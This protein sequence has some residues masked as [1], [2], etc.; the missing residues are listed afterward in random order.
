MN[1]I[2]DYLV[3]KIL[4]EFILI[5]M[6]IIRLALWRVRHDI[7]SVVKNHYGDKRLNVET[8][9]SDSHKDDMGLFRD[10]RGYTPTPYDRLKR[11]IDYLKLDHDDVFIDF[12]CGKGRV[13]FMVAE[14]KLKK[15]IGVELDKKLADIAHD[16][17]RNLRLQNTPI[18][19]INADAA[20]FAVEEGTVFFL[21]DPFGY[22]TCEKVVENI[23][24]SLINRPRKIRILYWGHEIRFL[25]ESQD[26]LETDGKIDNGDILICSNK[27][28]L[29]S[30]HADRGGAGK[31]YR[32]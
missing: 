21:F 26:W 32:G 18:E 30:T 3:Y 29:N 5:F 24:E 4:R 25:L 19:I 11:I 8:T 9:E 15:V 27:S 23:K 14:Q 7:S 17:I 28:Y 6:S 22:K 31:D 12:G 13:I 10:M 20:T 2:K 1:K 16:N